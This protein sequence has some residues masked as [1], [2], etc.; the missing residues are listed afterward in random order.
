MIATGGIGRE[1]ST[2]TQIAEIMWPLLS[3]SGMTRNG[4][5]QFLFEQDEALL[6]DDQGRFLAVFTQNGSFYAANMKVKNPKFRLPFGG[7]A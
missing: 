3:V 7:P 5:L 2:P 4:N 1:I 6:T